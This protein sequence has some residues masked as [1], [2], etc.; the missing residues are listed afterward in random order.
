M[1][2]LFL[3]LFESYIDNVV[4]FELEKMGVEVIT[5][6]YYTPDD[7][8]HDD[9]LYESLSSDIE[10]EDCDAVFTV[11]VWPL[12]SK[13]AHRYGK[14]YLAW[15]YDCPQNLSKDDYLDYEESFIFL[16]DRWEVSDYRSRG[17]KSVYHMPL[18]VSCD[19]WD[20]KLSGKDDDPIDISLVGS[21][22]ESTFPGLLS[23]MDPYEKG[24]FRGIADAQRKVFGYYMIDDLITDE[25]LKKIDKLLRKTPSDT[26][27]MLRRRMSYSIATYLTFQDRLSFLSLL[28]KR[29]DLHFYTGSIPDNIKPLLTDVRLNGWADY[30]EDM[31]VIFKNSRINLCPTLRAIRS[32]IPLRALDIMGCKGLLLTPYQSE[33][34]ENFVS[35]EELYMYGSIEEAFGLVDRLL[36]N[37][38]ERK[39]IAAKGYE[40]VRRDFTYND[41][42]SRMFEIAGL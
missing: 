5:H 18:A 32:G 17:L 38:S 6:T 35:G 39:E 15:S 8:Y 25:H 24:F 40:K 13:A 16:F 12:V 29:Y 27:H 26:M 11:N 37:D 9:K 7:F 36:S 19:F 1:K 20:E 3:R 42:F 21:V 2:L 4:L 28:S 10:K 33:L 34:A 30:E 23:A 22:Y 41:R 31:P 14:K